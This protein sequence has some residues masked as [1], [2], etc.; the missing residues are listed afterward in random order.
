MGSKMS[1]FSFLLMALL[2]WHRLSWSTAGKLSLGWVQKVIS[3]L[4]VWDTGCV[5]LATVLPSV[6]GFSA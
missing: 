2:P 3:K 5:S 1:C 4:G 6:P